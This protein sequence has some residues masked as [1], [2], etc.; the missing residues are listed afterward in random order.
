[1]GAPWSRGRRRARRRC[2]AG[3]CPRPGGCSL[4]RT[5]AVPPRARRAAPRRGP[6]AASTGSTTA[7]ACSASAPLTDRAAAARQQLAEHRLVRRQ[8]AARPSRG[9]RRVELD[10][11]LPPAAQVSRTPLR[12]AASALPA[13]STKRV[14]AQR[15]SASSRTSSA[16]VSV[17]RAGST[18]CSCAYAGTCAPPASRPAAYLARRPAPV[19]RGRRAARP[20]G[21]R[22]RRPPAGGSMATSART[23]S[24]WFWTTSRTAP[25][26]S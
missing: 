13:R 25:A 22:A 23:C 9:V 5:G 8:L 15:G 16:A 4:R 3:R 10:P 7:Q 11:A 14:P 19:P 24:R 17:P 2:G 26:R 12:S 21:A 6:S 18:P 20:A 1:M